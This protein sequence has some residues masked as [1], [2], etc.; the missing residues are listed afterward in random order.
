MKNKQVM[1]NLMINLEKNEHLLNKVILHITDEKLLKKLIELLNDYV[2]L[3]NK[4]NKYL[5]KD[6][7]DDKVDKEKIKEKYEE[8]KNI[9]SFL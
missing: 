3:K 2:M 1:Y 5:K 8:Y 4:I 6:Y 7:T 9:M